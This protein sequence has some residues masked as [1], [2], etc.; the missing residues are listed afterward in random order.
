[1]KFFDN[2]ME[3][4]LQNGI[5]ETKSMCGKRDGRVNNTI[6]NG[7]KTMMSGSEWYH[8]DEVEDII[9]NGVKS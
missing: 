6:Q 1:M 5:K 7:V 4:A 2:K 9:Q 8:Q 3:E